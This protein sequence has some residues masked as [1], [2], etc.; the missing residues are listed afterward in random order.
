VIDGMRADLRLHA[1]AHEALRG[2]ND[3]VIML[4]D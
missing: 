1:L 4:G 3:H 2:R